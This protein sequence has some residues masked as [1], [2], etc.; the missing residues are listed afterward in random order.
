MSFGSQ[1]AWLSG[2]IENATQQEALTAAKGE[3]QKD[4]QNHSKVQVHKADQALHPL[5]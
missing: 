1:D 4:F 3:G 2:K 5:Q